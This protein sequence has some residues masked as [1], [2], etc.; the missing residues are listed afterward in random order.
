ML[1]D[2]TK[3]YNRRGEQTATGDF[4][5]VF[6]DKNDNLRAAVRHVRMR[7][8]GHFMMAETR[9]GKHRLVLSGAYGG[10]GLPMSATRSE[11]K[12]CWDRCEYN[13]DEWCERTYAWED[14]PTANWESLL[15]LPEELR[16]EFWHPEKQGWNS[17]GSE[18]KNLRAWAKTNLSALRKAGK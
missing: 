13:R 3:G 1:I 8:C 9:V 6:C 18:A 2:A 15:P 10:D 5:I 17:C 7:Q 11:P 14:V 16:R 12:K 4:L